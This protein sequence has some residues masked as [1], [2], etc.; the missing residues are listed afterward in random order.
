MAVSANADRDAGGLC[1]DDPCR[2]PESKRNRF[3]CRLRGSHFASVCP[4]FAAG[5]IGMA[6]MGV[7]AAKL[8]SANVRSNWI[9]QLTNTIARAAVFPGILCLM[10]LSRLKGSGREQNEPVR[11]QH[12]N[13]GPQD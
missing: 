9:E 1:A 8:D 3:F 5:V 12:K 13:D 10:W 11:N 2:D 4:A 6:R 7:F